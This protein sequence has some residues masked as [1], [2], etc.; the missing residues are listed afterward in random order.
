[1]LSG[2]PSSGAG[3]GPWACPV[4]SPAEGGTTCW[5][6]SDAR[7]ATSSGRVSGSSANGADR[8]GVEAASERARVSE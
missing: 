7:G 6:S 2:G 5:S 8:R 1:V 3:F 4:T